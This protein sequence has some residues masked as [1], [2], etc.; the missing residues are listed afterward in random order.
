MLLVGKMYVENMF[1][2]SLDSIFMAIASISITVLRTVYCIDLWTSSATTPNLLV[3]VF[4]N[5]LKFIGVFFYFFFFII[6]GR[7]M[8]SSKD[9]I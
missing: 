3:A 8:K 9:T 2:L 1:N 4:I 6:Y 7:K 5:S